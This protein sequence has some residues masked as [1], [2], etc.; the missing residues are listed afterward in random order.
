MTKVELQAD[1][2]SP[3][4]RC[5]SNIALR[6]K[7]TNVKMTFHFF[8]FYFMFVIS[9]QVF[10]I[11]CVLS[12]EGQVGRNMSQNTLNVCNKPLL[13]GLTDYWNI[14]NQHIV[15]QQVRVVIL[16]CQQV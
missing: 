12:E 4:A 2:I 10:R 8:L 16:S 11:Y 1:A 7:A 3:A 9:L 14:L 13:L 6:I 5:F 15:S